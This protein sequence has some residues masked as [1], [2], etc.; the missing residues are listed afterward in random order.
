MLARAAYLRVALTYMLISMP[1]GTSTI[2]GA[3][4]AILALS[5][6]RDETPPSPLNYLVMKSSP[7]NSF[8]FETFA[9]LVAPQQD[10]PPR[11]GGRIK[12]EAD[13]GFHS[14]PRGGGWALFTAA[15]SD[16]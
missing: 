4:Q 12:A 1:H 16:K 3:F 2:F 13:Q 6:Y 11:T 10:F 7:V 14:C 15:R 8:V 5:L 9:C